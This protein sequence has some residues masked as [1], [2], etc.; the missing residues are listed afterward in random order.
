[1]TGL[2]GQIIGPHGSLVGFWFS[3]QS[4]DKVRFSF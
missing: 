1:M 3:E 2:W 4:F